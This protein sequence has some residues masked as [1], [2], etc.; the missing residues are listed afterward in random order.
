MAVPPILQS[1]LITADEIQKR[2]AE[3]GQQISV[4]YEGKNPL[5][6]GVLRGAVIF[7]ADLIR[8][9]DCELKVDFISVRSYGESTRSSGQVQL[10][11]DLESSIEGEHVILVEDIVDTGLT[12]SYLLRNFESRRPSSLKVCSLLSKPSRRVV[13][14]PIDYLGFEVP[15]E[16]VVG[17][18]LDFQQKYRNLP[19][20]G[21]MRKSTHRESTVVPLRRSDRAGTK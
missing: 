8:H 4:D 13:E 1:S 3:I 11:K 20:I 15:D 18:G 16:F 17:Y 5:V 19:Y 10:I 14:V 12:I 2:T 6:V 9:M 21:I 7:H